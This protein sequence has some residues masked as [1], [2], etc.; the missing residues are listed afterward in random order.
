[1]CPEHD[2]DEILFCREAGCQKSICILCLSAAHLGHKVVAA[3]EETREV[4]NKMREEIEVTSRTL[5]AMITN[6]TNVSRKATTKSES[7]L[8]EI[9]QKKEEVVR[10]F[11]KMIKETEE[12]MNELN[13]TSHDDLNIITENLKLLNEIKKTC[14]DQENT[15]ADVSGKLETVESIKHNAAELLSKVGKYEYV[16]YITNQE[17]YIGEMTMGQYPEFPGQGIKRDFI[18]FTLKTKITLILY[19]VLR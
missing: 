2:K 3:D 13:V 10:D 8:E 9:K 5:T 17:V 15:Y 12:H 4:L 16:K 11:E 7:S 18:F 19:F 6:V 14:E 1:M